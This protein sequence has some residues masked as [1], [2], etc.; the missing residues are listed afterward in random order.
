MPVNHTTSRELK[1]QIMLIIY[2]V[3]TA[4]NPG[5]TLIN[6]DRVSRIRQI[7]ETLLITHDNSETKVVCKDV[8]SARRAFNNILHSYA[9][10]NEVV[11][12]DKYMK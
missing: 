2:Q 5:K 6:M 11:P 8:S 10:D 9:H 1:A 7:D 12:I 4:N 3:R